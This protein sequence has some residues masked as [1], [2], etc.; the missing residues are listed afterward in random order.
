MKVNMDSDQ[1][2]ART[3]LRFLVVLAAVCAT[4]F[5]ANVPAGWRTYRSSDHGFMLAYPED[6]TFYANST[7]AQLPSF[8]SVM[9]RRLLASNIAGASIRERGSKPPALQ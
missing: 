3:V 1:R 8:P 9:R 7:E 4:S 5:A 2:Y 6:F